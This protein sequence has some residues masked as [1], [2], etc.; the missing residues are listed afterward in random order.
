MDEKAKAAYRDQAQEMNYEDPIQDGEA[1]VLEST[2]IHR[3]IMDSGRTTL[4]E[5]IYTNLETLVP[6]ALHEL[7]KIR[8]SKFSEKDWDKAVIDSTLQ[9]LQQHNAAQK[10]KFAWGA[11]HEVNIK[12]PLRDF[13]M[14]Q[15]LEDAMSPAGQLIFGLLVVAAVTFFT[16]KE[17]K[18]QNRSMERRLLAEI[19]RI[20]QAKN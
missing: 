10:K 2:R 15:G 13:L 11:V 14:E 16:F 4:S 18:S 5:Q 3:D 8:E 9:T 7:S 12:K 20:V 1:E 19:E 17:V 6:E